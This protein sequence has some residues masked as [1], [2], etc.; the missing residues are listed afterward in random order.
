MRA[1]SHDPKDLRDELILLLTLQLS[2]VHKQAFGVL[3][4]ADILL[5]EQRQERICELYDEVFARHA[6]TA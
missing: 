2:D 1:K 5:Y 4:T 3:T 6:A